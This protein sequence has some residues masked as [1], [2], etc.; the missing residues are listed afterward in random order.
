MNAFHRRLQRK[1][2]RSPIL[3]HKSQDRS[4]EENGRERKGKGEERKGVETRHEESPVP[5]SALSTR[6]SKEL[7]LPSR[8]IALKMLLVTLKIA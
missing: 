8:T 4:R 6:L 1:E 3:R 5:S 2:R 7:Q